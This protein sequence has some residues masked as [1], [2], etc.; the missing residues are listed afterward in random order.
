MR[1]QANIVAIQER[2][3]L[4]WL[5]ARMPP[6][7]TSNRLSAVGV[8]GALIALAGYVASRAHPAFLWLASLGLVL[9]WF[10]DSMDGSL[11]RARKTE[12]PV[13]GYFLDH[14]IDSLGN[15]IIMLG[16]GASLFVRMD[17][18]LA[19]LVGYLLM[20]IHVVLKQHAQGVFQISFLAFGPTELRICI[21]AMNTAMW[22]WG[23]SIFVVHGIAFTP[24]DVPVA[25]AALVLGLLFVLETFGTARLLSLVDPPQAWTARDPVGPSG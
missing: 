25:F 21:V 5:C 7:V 12:R 1:I 10:G 19:A 22:L 17:V 3:L 4:N 9:H 14:S 11:A 15:A 20:T 6:F 18:A 2:R 16:L 8:I 13:F 24:Y 23:G